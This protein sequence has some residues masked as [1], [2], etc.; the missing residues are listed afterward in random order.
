MRLLVRHLKGIL[1][2]LATSFRSEPIDSIHEE[3]VHCGLIRFSMGKGERG[4]TAITLRLIQYLAV[5]TLSSKDDP[6]GITVHPRTDRPPQDCYAASLSALPAALV[7]GA[8]RQTSGHPTRTVSFFVSYLQRL[9]RGRRLT[10][11]MMTQP[12]IALTQHSMPNLVA[13]APA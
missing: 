13:A 1:D 2:D 10:A 4:A 3:A 11:M 7:R 12:K 9:S 6:K 5:I 8:V